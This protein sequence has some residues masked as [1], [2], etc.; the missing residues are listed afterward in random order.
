MLFQGSSVVHPADGLVI[1]F[2][3]ST[4]GIGVP[5]AFKDFVVPIPVTP[6]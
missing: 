4:S 5:E 1:S 2:P 3:D 6:P